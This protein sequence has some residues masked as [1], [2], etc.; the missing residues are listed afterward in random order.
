MSKKNNF[1]RKNKKGKNQATYK[2]S[3]VKKYRLSG[4]ILNISIIIAILVAMD[5]TIK[6]N[7]PLKDYDIISS[8]AD[9]NGLEYETVCAIINVESGFNPN[10][11]SNKGAS[12]YMQLMEQTANWG[13]E[14]LGIE[15]KTFDDIFE[16]ELNIAIG[17]WYFAN[18]YRQFGS[19]NL[20][21]ISYNAGSGNVSKWL[22]ANNYDEE[23]TIKNIPF[24]ETKNYYFKIKFNEFV[25]K[26]LLEFY[27]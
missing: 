17:T 18:L 15:D 3:N 16:P 23:E 21:I 9:A 2:D 5:L 12:G 20:A 14:S 24:K 7:F 10:A 22:E 19:E 8:Y 11:V 1:D 4:L 13:I 26:Y 6:F 25:Y 27:Y